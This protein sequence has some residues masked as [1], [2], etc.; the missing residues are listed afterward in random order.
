MRMDA[1]VAQ[2]AQSF[3]FCRRNTSDG[4]VVVIGSLA[5]RI[6]HGS[7]ISRPGGETIE[8]VLTELGYSGEII[9]RLAGVHPVGDLEQLEV[10]GSDFFSHATTNQARGPTGQ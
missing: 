5:L 4:H 7:G 9:E 6:R 10:R 1:G 3:L 2:R 8:N